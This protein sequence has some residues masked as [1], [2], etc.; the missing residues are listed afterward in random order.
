MFYIILD[1]PLD[2]ERGT[3]RPFTSLSVKVL[4]E[5]VDEG[6]KKTLTRIK[7]CTAIKKFIKNATNV[8]LNKFWVIHFSQYV[9]FCE[10]LSWI[11]IGIALHKYCLN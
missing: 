3:F 2:L 1:A 10:S 6:V 7:N 8:H 5:L 11:G 9:S 4:W